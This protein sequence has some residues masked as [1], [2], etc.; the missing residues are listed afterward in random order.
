MICFQLKEHD[1]CLSHKCVPLVSRESDGAD[2]T[3]SHAAGD[4]EIRRGHHNRLRERQKLRSVCYAESVSKGQTAAI[5][6]DFYRI[7]SGDYKFI[8]V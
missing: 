5:K 4:T 1:L 2:L 8:I 6:C 7:Q 3:L